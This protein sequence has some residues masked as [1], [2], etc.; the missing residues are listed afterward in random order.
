MID[1]YKPKHYDEFIKEERVRSRIKP[2]EIQERRV[3]RKGKDRCRLVRNQTLFPH[4]RTFSGKANSRAEAL[5]AVDEGLKRVIEEVN[6]YSYKIAD[7]MCNDNIKRAVH[8]NSRS[9]TYDA[10]VEYITK[11]EDKKRMTM[12]LQQ[13]RDYTAEIGAEETVNI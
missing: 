8:W 12:T 5:K 9:K 10:V 13:W 2:V 7:E 3:R 6:A 1:A 4:Q 11:A